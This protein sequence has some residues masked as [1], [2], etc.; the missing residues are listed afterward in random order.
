MILDMWR[1]YIGYLEWLS[2]TEMQEELPR[3]DAT[4]PLLVPSSHLSVASEANVVADYPD[5]VDRLLP[6]HMPIVKQAYIAALEGI[7]NVAIFDGRTGSSFTFGHL[8]GLAAHYA[9]EINSIDKSKNPVCAYSPSFFNFS[10]K[11]S[12]PFYY[13]RSELFF[14]F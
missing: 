9:S 3:W 5:L 8:V 13:R 6:I 12:C 4:P 10:F 11:S 7:K 2:G 14:Y 1:T